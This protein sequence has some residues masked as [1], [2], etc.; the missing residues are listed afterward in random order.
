VA[1]ITLRLYLAGD[2][3]V[4][5]KAREN[6]QRLRERPGCPIDVTIIDVLHEPR[7]ADEARI[8]ATPTLVC[9]HPARSK[10]IIGDL[11][12]IDKIV[13]FLGLQRGDNDER[14]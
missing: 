9:E 10:R 1:K 2:T 13:E 4:S 3:V 6:L 8:L 12:D 5:Q 11:S 7:L 14:C